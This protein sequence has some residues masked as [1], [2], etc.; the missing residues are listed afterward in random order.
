MYKYHGVSKKEEEGSF[1]AEI[2]VQAHEKF[3][4]IL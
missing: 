4:L 2:H 3:Y 1:A